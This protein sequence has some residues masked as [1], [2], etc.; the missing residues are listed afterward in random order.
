LKSDKSRE[1]FLAAIEA[2]HNFQSRPRRHLSNDE[3]QRIGEYG[4]ARI[5][6]RCGSVEWAEE[7]RKMVADL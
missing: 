2:I 4:Y 3:A 5:L 6:E 1:E 7:F